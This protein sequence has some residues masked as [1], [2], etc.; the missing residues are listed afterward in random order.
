M[1]RRVLFLLLS[2]LLAGCQMKNTELE[3]GMALRSS[4][5]KA[6]KCS[7]A[8]DITA[9]YGD[10]VQSFSMDCEADKD[11]NVT[12]CVTAPE[13]ISGITGGIEK[14][15]GKLTFDEEV[16]YFELF[17]DD[18]LSPV[19]APWILMKTLR[20]GYLKSAGMDED[21]IFLTIDD[22]YEEDALQV[23]IWLDEN[24]LPEKADILQ[25]GRRILSLKVKNFALS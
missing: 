19:S 24:D 14:E 8:V 1:R 4:V 16:L 21:R 2:V 15:G 3:R 11:G 13:T 6:E 12:F 25:E 20:A 17:A 22:S 23:D 9:D 7:F 18:I 10:V 5:L